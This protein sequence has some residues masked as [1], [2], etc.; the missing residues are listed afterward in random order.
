MKIKNICRLLSMFVVTVIFCNIVTAQENAGYVIGDYIT[1]RTLP[2]KRIE[3]G[4]NYLLINDTID[5]FDFRDQEI[6]NVSYAYQS[7]ALNDMKGCSLFFN[8]GLFE[9]TTLQAGYTYRNL[10]YILRSMDL[11]SISF[12]FKQAVYP[13]N[14]TWLPG[15]SIDGGIRVDFA[16]DLIGGDEKEINT[17]L[18]RFPSNKITVKY[19]DKD[20]YFFKTADEYF[21]VPRSRNGIVKSA[22]QVS[23]TDLNDK[24][25]FLRL[26]TGKDYHFFMPSFYLEFGMTWIDATIDSTL[27]EYIPEVEESFKPD[28]PDLPLDL[29]RKE[30]YLKT[31]ISMMFDTPYKTML[32]FG[33]D[34]IHFIRDAGLDYMKN[35]HIF[36]MDIRYNVIK[37]LDLVIGGVMYYRQLNGILPF[38]YNRY[39][40]TTFDHPYGR[41]NF[42]I[43]Y[44]F[45]K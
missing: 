29:S 39:T 28:I 37:H 22:P 13:D 40:Q 21:I 45:G 42:G 27:I 8:Y 2:Q 14:H 12:S 11:N 33:Y 43:S 5:I 6:E 7:I 30:A 4:I 16:Y 38:T 15:I 20:V 31:G 25:G 44:A 32:I 10:D 26:I 19:N 9:H 41:A 36:R 23:L 34:Y 3:L 24:T 18:G 17:L 1:I 35:N